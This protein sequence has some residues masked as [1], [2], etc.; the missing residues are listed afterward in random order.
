VLEEPRAVLKALGVDLHEM[1]SHGVTNWCCGGG[2][3]VFV[4]NRAAP[5]RQA[6]FKIKMD[7]VNAT[8][9]EA[10]VTACGSCRLNFLAGTQ[11]AGWNKGIESLVELV[12][13]QLATND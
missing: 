10:V 13:Q 12:G 1:Q 7:Q 8:G 9:A 11:Q 3:G 5:L 4:I 6:A 2:A